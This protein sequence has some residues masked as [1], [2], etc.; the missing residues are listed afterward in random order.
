MHQYDG[1]ANYTVLYCKYKKIRETL[2]R[3]SIG[4]ANITAPMI[5]TTPCIMFWM[6]AYPLRGQVGGGWALEF[7]RI[8]G[9]VKCH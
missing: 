1:A 2:L 8:L 5:Y 9:P 7:E 6:R 4:A 3:A